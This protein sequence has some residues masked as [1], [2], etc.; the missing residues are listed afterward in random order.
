MSNFNTIF[1]SIVRIIESLLNRVLCKKTG[2][3]YKFFLD[4]VFGILKSSSLILTDVGFSLN[5]K[6]SLKKVE[7]RLCRN[8]QSEISISTKHAFISHC[9]SLMNQNR[10]VFIVDD[11]DI[12]KPYGKKFEGLMIVRDGS[13]NGVLEKGLQVTA[14][15]G[16]SGNFKHPIPIMTIAHSVHDKNYTSNNN[17]TNK[18]L[19]SIFQHLAP[20][21]AIFVF[22]RGYDDQKLM[23]LIH[24]E[25]QYFLIRIRKN[26]AI[27]IKNKKIDIFKIAESRKGKVVIETTYKGKPETL[28]ASHV[29]GRINGFKSLV[30]IVFSYGYKFEEPIILI[31]NKMVHSKDDLISLALNYFSRWKIEEIF[32]FKKVEFGMENFRVKSQAAIN[33][34]LFLL[35]MSVAI[36]A[37]I[38]ETQKENQIFRFLIDVSKQIRTDV[39]INYYQV[40]SGLKALFASNKMGVQNYKQIERWEYEK[41]SLFNSLELNEKKRVRS[42]RKIRINN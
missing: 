35:D 41:M 17:V 14:V 23:R 29:V 4:M 39:S 28:K 34:L 36:L 15:V 3:Q 33:N 16:L 10:M 31:T 42:N 32:R 21:N 9:L 2:T 12:V 8:L 38:I 40:L 18:A 6:S 37:Q 13:K 24:S 27:F 20:W 30:T 11:S 26:R 5:E 19:G 25:N 22:D 1:Q 7:E